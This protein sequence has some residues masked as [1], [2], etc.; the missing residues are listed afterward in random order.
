M[1]TIKGYQ[2]I[3]LL[4]VSNKKKKLIVKSDLKLLDVN[5]AILYKSN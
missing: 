5:I 2:N 4:T 1:N 3:S